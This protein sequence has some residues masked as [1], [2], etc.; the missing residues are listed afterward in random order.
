MPP[1]KRSTQTAGDGSA[2]KR[3]RSKR[4]ARTPDGP[5][6]ATVASPPAKVDVFG[7]FGDTTPTDT[8]RLAELYGRLI[9]AATVRYTFLSGLLADEYDK[10]GLDALRR[11]HYVV[12]PITGDEVPSGESPT[13]LAKLEAEAERTLERLLVQAARL[14]ID[15][16]NAEAREKQA[17]AQIAV[18][19]AYAELRGDDVQDADVRRMMQRAVL[20]SANPTRT[21]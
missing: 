17:A 12:N 20:A 1:R 7:R 3:R 13:A 5:E 15:L 4:A 14:G 8:A 6:N 21:G 9:T 10:H 11:V 2:G 18:L 16:R 19:V